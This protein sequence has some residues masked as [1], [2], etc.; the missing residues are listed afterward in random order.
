MSK[1]QRRHRLFRRLTAGILLGGVLFVAAHFSGLNTNLPFGL[2]R[3]RLESIGGAGPTMPVRLP[4]GARLEEDVAYGDHPLQR[5]DVYVPAAEAAKAAEAAGEGGAPIVF[6]VHG[7]GWQH[8]DKAALDV[9]QNKVNYFLPRG[10]VFVSMNYRLV[11]EVEPTDQV[12]DVAA[13]LAY[14]QQHAA[15]W[16]ADGRRVVTMGHS[17]GAHLVTL[18]ASVPET[19]QRFGV[20]PWLGT[21]ALDSAAY[22][23]VELMRRRHLQLYDRAFGQ[24]RFLWEE[25]SPTLR[26]QST[27]PPM[28]LVCSALW[29]HSCDQAGAY[30]DLARS[31]GGNVT[32]MRVGLIHRRVNRNVG[33]PGRLTDTVG[34]FIRALR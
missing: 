7:G 10:Y 2:F 21:V 4:A 28:L 32:V 9:V 1:G 12:A 23:V 19:A 6:M 17:A 13:A 30:A 14:V 31:L 22:D 25:V 33:L 8:G 16:G 5:L 15:N 24:D 11:P 34:G 3:N 27:P 20:Q 26:L 29:A 18:L